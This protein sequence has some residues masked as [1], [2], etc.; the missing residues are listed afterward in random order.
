MAVVLLHAAV[1]VYGALDGIRTT[2]LGV[3]N[4]NV[5]SILVDL[6]RHAP[7]DA[8]AAAQQVRAIVDEVKRTP[9]V[10]AAAA[11]FGV[12]GNEA[13]TAAGDV[14]YDDP[15]TGALERMRMIM[16]PA[17]GDYFDVLGIPLL[18]GRAL[19]DRDR[20]NTERVAVADEGAA[21]RL[22]GTLPRITVYARPP[23]RISRP[24][25]SGSPAKALCQYRWSSMTTGCPPRDTSSLGRPFDR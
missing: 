17:T 8:E 12:P 14:G 23:T 4:R 7:A 9:G 21:R 3:S 11:S 1:T 2:D 16:V 13:V 18:R 6:R 24:T 22:F 19:N 10:A 25:T 15:G 5:L 20:A